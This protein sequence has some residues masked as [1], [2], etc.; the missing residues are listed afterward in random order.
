M[1]TPHDNSRRGGPDISHFE[2]KILPSGSLMGRY[3]ALPT[4]KS[5]LNQ[6]VQP[7]GTKDRQRPS[8]LMV[9][10]FVTKFLS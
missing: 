10:Y 6:A 5:P 9:E 7:V 1:I 2:Y 3:P 4:S 8:L